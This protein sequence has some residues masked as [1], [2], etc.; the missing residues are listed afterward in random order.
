MHIRILDLDGSV[1]QQ[2]RLLRRTQ[3]AIATLSTWGPRIRLACSWR[4]FHRFESAL[5]GHLGSTT[6]HRPALTFYG[7]GDF[8]HVSLALLRRLPEPCNLLVL[9][10][11]PDWMRGVPLLHCG[12]WLRRALTL[13]QVVR[14]FH[15]GGELDFDNSFRHLA[16]WADLRSGRIT[17]FPAVRQFRSQRWG[18]VAHEPLRRDPAEPVDAGRIASLVAPWREELAARPLYV[19]LDK[20]V[21]RQDEAVVNWDSGHLITAEVLAVLGA[22][23][24]RAKRLAGMDVVGDWSP[25]RVEGLFRRLLHWVEHP[26]LQIDPAQATAHNERHNLTLLDGI[27]AGSLGASEVRLGRAA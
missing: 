13:Q 23:R 26:P 27:A 4:R 20:D 12:T 6:D 8:H 15:L 17:V 19:S 2:Q 25:V 18:R 7:S 22:F 1:V 11:H 16:P 14:I 21:M 24:A 10:K 5:A 3:A 9:D